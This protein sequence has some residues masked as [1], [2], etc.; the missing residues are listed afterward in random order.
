MTPQPQK[1]IGRVVITI[2]VLNCFLGFSPA[3]TRAQS[4]RAIVINADQPNV[5]TLEQ[6]HYLLAQMHRRDLDLKTKALE[7]LD[8]NAINGL[9]FEVL[10]TLMELGASFNQANA[11]TN[12]L[13]ARNKAFDAERR[14][15]LI[16][17]RKKLRDESV[18]LTRDISDLQTQ[19]ANAKTQEEK[20]QLDAQIAAK[21]ELRAKID[22]EVEFDDN[23]IKALG[24]ASGDFK[25]TDAQVQ[26]DASKFPT[27]VFD[28]AFKSTAKTLIERFNSA[29]SLNA[30]MMLE[31]VLQLQYEIVSKQ[32]TLLRDEV[33]PGE[34]LLFLELPQT[35]NVTHHEA[36]KKWAQ[37]WWR[38]AGYSRRTTAT[39]TR[40]PT[41]TPTPTNTP[42]TTATGTSTPA[43]TGTSTPTSASRPESTP[44]SETV[45]QHPIT[46]AEDYNSVVNLAENAYGDIRRDEERLA[47]PTSATRIKSDFVSLDKVAPL[48]EIQATIMADLND[49]DAKL[50]NRL[51]RAVELIPRQSSLNVNDL[52]LKTKSGAFSFVASFLFGFGAR[53]NVQRQ[54]EQF[55]QFVQ[56]ELYSSAFGKGSREFGWTF[57]PMP[58]T[59]RLLSGDRTTYAAVI[60]PNDATTLLLESNGCYFPRSG[61]QPVS[62]KE[63]VDKQRWGITNGSSRNCGSGQAFVVPIPN[64]GIGERNGF[65]VK[66]VS[67]QPVAK[68]KRIVVLVS[69][70]NF[71]SQIGVLVNGI[72]LTQAIGLAQ[73]LLRDD[74]RA[75]AGALEDLK[76]EKVRGRIE[77]IDAEQI[78]FSFEVDDFAG[79]PTITLIAPG[80]AI[81]INWLAVYVNGKAQ[82]TL[83]QS[84]PMFGVPQ[85]EKFR[86]DSVEVFRTAAG[87]LK[88][89]IHGAGFKPTLAPALTTLYVNGV[90]R[91]FTAVSSELIEVA[92]FSPPAD[93]RLQV[94]LVYDDETITSESVPNPGVPKIGNVSV[95][96][97]EP[98]TEKKPGILVVKLEG[99]GFP[100]NLKSDDKRIKITVASSTEVYLTIANPNPAEIVVLKD[101]VTNVSITA[102]IRRGEP[103]K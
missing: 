13:L 16:A 60:V 96:S 73:P 53:L 76:N 5:W 1:L 71:S 86:I 11:V 66:G 6:A 36:D 2:F 39:L 72:P 61:Y 67:Y 8:P 21:T 77:R 69:G 44:A 57:T 29:P 79:T 55:S 45:N 47:G 4:R 85:P 43:P 42:T 102:L 20:D 70:A 34:R 82:T 65:W 95:V 62:F 92:E 81:D 88:A 30:S 75:G 59:D 74:S 41:G 25:S 37:S 46:T 50:S 63:T 17:E 31:N 51:V 52:K 28:D 9:R 97:Y 18:Q 94:S 27:S 7:D 93:D 49:S 101:P 48:P 26:F 22:K 90:G 58:G 14:P 87:K 15:Q 24:D 40:T 56:Q 10:R 80:K 3:I 68:G 64:G 103:R 84:K 54:R 38:I 23:E 12:K 100:N 33:G 91:T 89:L 98:A 83:N 19:K 35:V 99:T 78:V 32:L